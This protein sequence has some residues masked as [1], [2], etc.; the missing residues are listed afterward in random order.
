ME[1]EGTSI[2]KNSRKENEIE[3]KISRLLADLIW[4]LENQNFDPKKFNELYLEILICSSR[5]FKMEEQAL[6]SGRN[7]DCHRK[8]MSYQLFSKQLTRVQDLCAARG[9]TAFCSALTFLGDCFSTRSGRQ[10]EKGFH[11]WQKSE[12]QPV[13]A[14]R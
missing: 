5:I 4:H 7:H 13:F 11:D 10:S 6:S 14:A 9:I 3:Q 1:I 8:S 12:R 2:H